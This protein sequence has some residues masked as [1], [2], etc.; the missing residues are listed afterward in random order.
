MADGCSRTMA[1][2]DDGV[3]RQGEKL[4]LDGSY[5][6]IEVA[7]GEIDTAD[8]ALEKDVP[9]YHHRGIV[10]EKQEGYVSLAMARSVT[11]FQGEARSLDGFAM[12]NA[13]I[14]RRCGDRHA[15]TGRKVEFR[16]DKL[17]R[18]PLPDHDRTLGPPLLQSGNSPNVIGMPVG[19]KDHRR[20]QVLCVKC[21]DYIVWLKSRIKYQATPRFSAVG[22][23]SVLGEHLGNNDQE[24]GGRHGVNTGDR[25]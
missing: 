20:L 6:C 17:F 22:D 18:I 9:R 23:E 21:L 4:F 1:R 8:T 16:V 25:C 11:N 3:V 24:F 10:F 7:I 2:Q 12:D 19:D 15:I 5:Q 14:S 13:A